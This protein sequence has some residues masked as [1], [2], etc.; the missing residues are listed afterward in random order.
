M[1]LQEERRNFFFKLLKLL[2]IVGPLIIV[3]LIGIGKTGLDFNSL[4]KKLMAYAI[5]LL[6]K[7]LFDYI[8]VYITSLF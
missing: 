1:P 4:Y 8:A 2:V 6:G 7:K 3:I 5:L